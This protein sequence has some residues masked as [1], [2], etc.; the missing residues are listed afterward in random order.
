M[1][2]AGSNL[3]SLFINSSYQGYFIRLCLLIYTIPVSGMATR[4]AIYNEVTAVVDIQKHNL[5][6]SMLK[7]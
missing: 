2:I 6:W 5:Q 1:I 3:M 7:D 4:Q